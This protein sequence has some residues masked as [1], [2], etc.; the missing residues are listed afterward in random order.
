MLFRSTRRILS[1]FICARER[2]PLLANR[3]PGHPGEIANSVLSTMQE[4]KRECRGEFDL[5]WEMADF[6]RL[7]RINNFLLKKIGID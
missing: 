2:I 3:Y 4:A 6:P 1:Y 5:F 7:P